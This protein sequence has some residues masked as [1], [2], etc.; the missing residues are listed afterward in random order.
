M[1]AKPCLD[2]N[3]LTRPKTKKQTNKQKTAKRKRED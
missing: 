3:S 1:L 2:T